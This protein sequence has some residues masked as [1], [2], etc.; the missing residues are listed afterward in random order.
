[1]EIC[2]ASCLSDI[3]RFI[4]I[5]TAVNIYSTCK[6]L[7]EA[8]FKITGNYISYT[9]IMSVVVRY[10]TK[11]NIL[12]IIANA[13]DVDINKYRGC[14]FHIYNTLGTTWY[15]IDREIKTDIPAQFNRPNERGDI[16]A[17]DD[18]LVKTIL[19]SSDG[20]DTDNCCNE[21]FWRTNFKINIPIDIWKM[22]DRIQMRKFLLP[23]INELLT[24]NNKIK[25]FPNVED[26]FPITIRAKKD[27]IKSE[28]EKEVISDIS[29]SIELR[30]DKL[31]Y[32]FQSFC[33]C[34]Q[35]N[36]SWISWLGSK[37]KFLIK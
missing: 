37:L 33:T 3:C 21:Y 13:S 24:E 30:H 16:S 9:N 4:D 29:L 5:K 32:K 14:F 2:L 11:T 19:L 7:R 26:I 8:A 22:A 34:N 18:G 12:Q 17:D 1:M 25:N 28:G 36:G 10:P 15:Y 35:S 23:I 27:K 31:A 20:S 6:R